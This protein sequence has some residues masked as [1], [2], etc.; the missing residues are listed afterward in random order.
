[1]AEISK[2]LMCRDCSFQQ[3]I[4]NILLPEELD[5]L[6]KNRY[7]V[8]Y[9]KGETIFKQGSALTHIA[10]IISG[11]AKIYIEGLNNKNLII[12]IVKND[13]IISGPGMNTDNK[14]HFTV[15]SIIETQVCLI[16]AGAFR[17]VMKTNSK[18][19]MAMLSKVNTQGIKN[20]EK[21]IN[22]TQKQIPGRIADAIF[23]LADVVHKSDVF[24]TPIS[25][26]DLAEMTAMTKESACR[27]LKYFNDAKLVKIEG[28][29]FE[30][31]N[32]DALKKIS[33]TG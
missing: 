27:I 13:E 11:M 10:C 22:L 6:N 18:F 8:K 28:N 5:L 1:M 33:L 21:F 20:F 14:H 24:D 19:T 9:K 30:L 7:E 26:Q 15:T 4:F 17:N 25:R 12:K 31:Q 23:Y 3:D 2:N 29:H 16:D 32:R